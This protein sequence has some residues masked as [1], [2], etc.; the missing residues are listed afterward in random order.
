MSLVLIQRG[1]CPVK[2]DTREER[3]VRTEAE[4]R[5]KQLQAQAPR[6]GSHHQEDAGRVRPRLSEGPGPA[7]TLVSTC[8]ARTVRVN[9]RCFQPPLCYG[10]PRGLVRRHLLCSG[11]CARCGGGGEWCTWRG[12]GTDR[13]GVK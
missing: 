13:A 5:V 12:V 10:R 11:C 3:H 9:F 6:P 1:K 4:V 2:R 7:G 8:S